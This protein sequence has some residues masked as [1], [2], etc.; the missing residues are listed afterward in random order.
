MEKNAK[1]KKVLIQKVSTHSHHRHD[2][3]ET[4]ACFAEQVEKKKK[5]FSIGHTSRQGT[6]TTN[7]HTIKVVLGGASGKMNVVQEQA[8]GEEEEEK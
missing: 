4:L 6:N 5:H 8:E 3:E 7:R 1:D 2:I